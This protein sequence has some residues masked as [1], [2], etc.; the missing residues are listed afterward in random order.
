MHVVEIQRPEAATLSK[1]KKHLCRAAFIRCIR[2][3]SI[4]RGINDSRYLEQVARSTLKPTKGSVVS[5]AWTRIPEVV[6]NRN[7]ARGGDPG[8]GQTHSR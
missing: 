2:C 1:P 6:A 7:E 5:E 4:A 8:S 3:P